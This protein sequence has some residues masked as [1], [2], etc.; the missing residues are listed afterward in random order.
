[1]ASQIHGYLHVLNVYI[2]ASFTL[3]ISSHDC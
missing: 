2:T 3:M 1:M